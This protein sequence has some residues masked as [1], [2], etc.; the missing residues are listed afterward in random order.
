MRYTCTVGS[1]D[2]LAVGA[3]VVVVE[4]EVV[5][6]EDVMH[7]LQATGQVRRVSGNLAQSSG[8]DETHM[9]GSRSPLQ[10]SRLSH[11]PHKAGQ[12]FR[13]AW[14]P[15]KNGWQYNDRVFSQ[16]TSSG[17]Y[18]AVTSV[19]EMAHSCNTPEDLRGASA[20]GPRGRGVFKSDNAKT[21]AFTNS[22][23]KR[24]DLAWFEDSLSAIRCNVAW[25]LQPRCK[26][27][28]APHKKTEETGTTRHTA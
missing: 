6:V 23:V 2:G 16:S 18:P 25:P 7:V 5:V 15:L 4:L 11:I 3:A 1:S 10:R 24:G 13:M 20:V 26:S 19:S 17:L 8:V 28:S 9:V 12:P 14:Y 21:K 27:T 22:S